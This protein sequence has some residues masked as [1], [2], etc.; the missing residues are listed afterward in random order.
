MKVQ[1]LCQ[2]WS[3]SAKKKRCSKMQQKGPKK[4]GQILK[5]LKSFLSLFFVL[6]T[7]KSASE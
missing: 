5:F 4:M 3:I 7:F 1:T 2:K 6:E